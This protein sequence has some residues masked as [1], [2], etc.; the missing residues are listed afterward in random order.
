[1]DSFINAVSSDR[2]WER[3]LC[4]PSEKANVRLTLEFAGKS[5]LVT[6]AGGFIGSALV[7]A[8]AAARPSSLILL[9]SSEHNL[10]EIQRQLDA[11]FPSLSCQ[12][13]LGRVEDNSTLHSVFGSFRPQIIFHAAAFKHVPLLE[14]NPFPAL[15]NN[16]LGTYALA[17]AALHYGSAKL[18]LISTDKA[19]YPHSVMGVSKRIAEL[20]TV[21]SNTPSCCM[22]AVRLVN[23]IGSTGS[24]LPIFR[25]QIQKRRPLSVTHP[26]ASRYFLSLPETLDAILACGASNQ[27]GKMF[28]PEVG[29]PVLITELA[30]FL[31]ET[32][33]NGVGANVSI[34]F[35]G[36]RPGDKL[37]ED[38]ISHEEIQE[39]SIDGP[40]AVIKTQTLSPA[41][42][43]TIVKDLSACVES[44]DLPAL[45]S[46]ISS[47]VP[48]Y[49]P[50]RVVLDAM[51]EASASKV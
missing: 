25:E 23:V 41:Q 4:E 27:G 19:V 1:L 26:Q 48:E 18:L 47:V 44:R 39:G 24:V 43:N 20:I 32:L 9:D 28:L 21:S 3:F 36:L 31:M 34:L 51:A 40:L 38:L 7:K 14:L 10:F 6:G 46:L 50:S 8:I 29:T 35:T 30:R 45:L 5:V 42:L 17:Q 49:V 22:N 33:E 13:V 37:T 2:G 12:A 11:T 16:V 15:R